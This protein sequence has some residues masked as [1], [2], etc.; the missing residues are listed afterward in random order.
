MPAAPT[1]AAAIRRAP[2]ARIS[3]SAAG[4]TRASRLAASIPCSP[5][6]AGRS[7][8]AGAVAC[9]PS[10]RA[11]A[12]RTPLPPEST[13]STQP[14]SGPWRSRGA[15]SGRTRVAEEAEEALEEGRT[16]QPS[17]RESCL[18]AVSTVS[19]DATTMLSSGSANCR[20]ICST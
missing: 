19:A 9:E 7:E 18:R 20:C 8:T 11:S 17:P 2:T 16:A 13:P 14:V 15:E 5:T 10:G 3:S 6:T 4:R 1:Q 12:T